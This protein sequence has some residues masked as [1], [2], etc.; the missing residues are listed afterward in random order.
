MGHEEIENKF[1]YRGIENPLE[2]RRFY[3][4]EFECE[5]FFHWYPFDSQTCYMEIMASNDLKDFIVYK[6]EN[7]QYLGPLD[8]TEYFV[9]KMDSRIEDETLLRIEI[10][11]QRRLLSLVLT[12]FLPTLTLNIIGH[13]S[14]YFKPVYFEGIMSLNV[15]VILV[16]TTMF[17]R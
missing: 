10:V 14:N 2:Y 11:I 8:L 5:Y 7:F 15:T 12:T 1:I 13:M 6:V 3:S 9:K 17:L 4:Q 16:L